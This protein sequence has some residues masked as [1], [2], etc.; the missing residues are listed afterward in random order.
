MKIPIPLIALLSGFHFAPPHA[1]AAE[2]LDVGALKRWVEDQG[3]LES[4]TCSFTQEKKLRA[5]RKP[6]VA[7]GRIWYRAPDDFRWQLGDPPRTILYHRG[8]TVTLVDVARKRARIVRP[9]SS[10]AGPRGAGGEFF[11]IGFPRSWKAFEETFEV[12]S[13]G[14]AGGLLTAELLPKSPAL[15]RGVGSVRF[16]IEE[17]TQK[18][19]SM[20]LELRDQSTITTTFEDALRNA[21]VP[22]SVFEPDLEGFS[23]EEAR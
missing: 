22:G 7:S 1:V 16:V 19:R 12:V 23:L 11:E 6:L 17:A 20:S 10:A 2:G 9:G 14:S 8:Q 21:A 15:A 4:L 13:L 5:L 18:L 3:A